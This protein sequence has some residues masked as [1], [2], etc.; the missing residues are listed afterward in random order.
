MKN[1]VDLLRQLQGRGVLDAPLDQDISH[2]K[3]TPGRNEG[4]RAHETEKIINLERHEKVWGKRAI[5][6]LLHPGAGLILYPERHPP[7]YRGSV[8]ALITWNT[9]SV[10]GFGCSWKLGIPA[11]WQYRS[12]L[13]F[14][15]FQSRPNDRNSCQAAS[16]AATVESLEGH[17][18]PCSCMLR[19]PMVLAG[20]AE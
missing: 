19:S 1:S 2:D 20:P 18:C 10:Q 8:R 11:D 6:R 14:L 17:L 16:A 15:R 5:R 12:I 3:S 7:A 4:K 9:S 13:S